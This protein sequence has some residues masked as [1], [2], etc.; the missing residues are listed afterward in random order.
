M[1]S[2]NNVPPLLWYIIVVPF[3]LVRKY[4]I[5]VCKESSFKLQVTEL[6]IIFIT[7]FVHVHMHIH[8]VNTSW[9]VTS[10][11]ALYINILCFKI[12]IITKIKTQYLASIFNF[13]FS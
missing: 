6:H 3:V 10:P 7:Q 2:I 9:P 12:R 5:I 11:S 4:N 8:R 1:Q 13:W